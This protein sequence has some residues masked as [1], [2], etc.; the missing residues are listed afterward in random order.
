MAPCN[1]AQLDF[2]ERTLPYAVQAVARVAGTQLALRP[3]LQSA[4][5]TL[6]FASG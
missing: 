1:R 6:T 2:F 5:T 3:S 4:P